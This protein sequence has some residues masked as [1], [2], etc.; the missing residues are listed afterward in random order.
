MAQTSLAWRER[1]NGEAVAEAAAAA[2]AAVVAVAVA[3]AAVAV[4]AAVAALRVSAQS[5]LCYRGFAP[6]SS[7][8]GLARGCHCS[9]ETVGT[10]GGFQ[11]GDFVVHARGCGCDHEALRAHRARALDEP[12]TRALS[13]TG[14]SDLSSDSTFFLKSETKRNLSLKSVFGAS[15]RTFGHSTLCRA[16]AT[17]PPP[18]GSGS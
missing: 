16:A 10:C 13:T 2:A 17:A 18:R 14:A 4:A 8:R 11:R 5:R 1:Q 15:H 12:A 3:A 7:A 9:D 6:P